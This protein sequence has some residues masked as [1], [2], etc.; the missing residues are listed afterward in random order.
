MRNGATI[1]VIIP[2]YNEEASIGRVLD[3]VPDWVDRVVVADNASTDRTATL[4]EERGALVVHEPVRGYG[5]ACLRA[6]A[7]LDA[8]DVVVFLDGDYSDNPA[9]MDLLVDPI[10][11]G[12]AEIVIGSRVLG[13]CEPGSLT[14]QQRYGN[15]FACLLM[16]W[17]YGVRYTD[18]GPFRAIRWS[19]LM[20][21]AMVDR[22]WGWTVELQVKAAKRHIQA[23]EVPVAYRKRIGISKIS[24]T[25]QGVVRAGGKIIFTIFK[26]A[27]Q[28]N[29]VRDS[30]QRLLVFSRY[31]VAGRTK[32]RL[33]PALGAEGAAT[34]HREMAAW[35]VRT[36]RR[37]ALDRY[38]DLEIQY[39]G[40]DEPAMAAWLGPDL[41]YCEQ[42]DGDL[43][44]RLHDAFA[45]AFDTGMKRVVT[46]GTDCPGLRVETIRKAFALLRTLDVV[47][48]PTD[49][50]GYYLIGLRTATA[51]LFGDVDWGADSV[52]STTLERANQ[53]GLSV[54]L[55]PTMRDVDTTDDLSVWDECGPEPPNG[56]PVVSMIVPALNEEN[57][58][59]NTLSVLG[60]HPEVEV[61]VVDGGSSDG[62]V[63][64]A[65]TYGA[66]VMCSASGRALQMNAGAEAARGE[67]LVFL[68]ADT[69]LPQGYV[70]E[71]Q[72]VLSDPAIV[73]GA[74]R[75]GI[76]GSGITYRLIARGANL[77][78]RIFQ[79]P[80]GDQCV[81]LRSD[82][83]EEIGGYPDLPIL[84]DYEFVRRLRCLGR[85]AL[86]DSTAFTSSRR[87]R[88]TGPWR[89]CAKHQLVLLGYHL[90]F[91]VNRLGALRK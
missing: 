55:L 83:F 90:G 72:R 57:G 25:V 78:S 52:F 17:I 49:D 91:E 51:S 79:L 6:I 32:T 38:T 35:T 89:Q 68:H 47:L 67:I 15:A 11:T 28:R 45:R 1:A 14:P 64:I 4:A 5:A 13:R 82:T 85:I 10:L 81:F 71:I 54:G 34:L 88:R 29:R 86:A 60:S 69:V 39:T 43:G 75:L 31:P 9:E 12:A 42:S 37:M 20:E 65:E 44:A 8:P 16:R 40:G 50:G 7:A 73:A 77:R 61:I 36:A 53:L 26:E 80:Y 41:R 48:G 84:E 74:F 62:T 33:I 87:W 18:L 30:M 19:T 76:D 23:I 70:A 24:R 27:V 66:T 63:S 2:V 46:I 58:I 22:T 21:L 59:G 3:D 56:S